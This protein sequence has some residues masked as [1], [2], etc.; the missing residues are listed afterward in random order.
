MQI[1]KD[2]FYVDDLLSSVD[3]TTT[4]VRLVHD[5]C[6]LLS[7]GGLNLRGWASNKADVLLEID[8]D[9]L[10]KSVKSLDL[11]SPLPAEKALGVR[12]DTAKDTL[13]IHVLLKDPVCTRRGLLKV[14]SSVFDPLGMV[15]PFILLVKLIFQD[16]CRTG[17]GWDDEMEPD[18]V[19]KW[20]AWLEDAP[21]LESY[22]ILQCLQ[23]EGMSGIAQTELHVF[24]DASIHAYGAVA[25][26]RV[27]DSGGN[28]HCFL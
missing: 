14:T 23:L 3:D 22:S 18:N 28:I 12:W 10:G 19:W 17:K 20:K 5:L 26:L 2:N 15:C 11:D 6:A 24:S 1:E 13:G 25:Y 9:K 16:E 21:K 7:H 4:A 27:L 8:P